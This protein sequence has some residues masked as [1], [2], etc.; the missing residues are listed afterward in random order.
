MIRREDHITYTIIGAPLLEEME[1]HFK[2]AGFDYEIL[3][4]DDIPAGVPK[5][6][7]L[8]G[9]V[10]KWGVCCVKSYMNSEDVYNLFLKVWSPTRY[11]VAGE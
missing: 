6:L 7:V 3:F 1:A 9:H 8:E 11:G 10:L 5:E 2:E 4:R